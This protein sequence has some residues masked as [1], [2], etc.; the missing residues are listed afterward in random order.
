M[1]ELTLKELREIAGGVTDSG[2]G[3]AQHDNSKTKH[4]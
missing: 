2:T 3:Q 4:H 1:R